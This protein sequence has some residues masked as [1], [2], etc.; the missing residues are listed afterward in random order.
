M[1]MSVNTEFKYFD[2]TTEIRTL[3]EYV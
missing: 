3:Y 2:K 1:E